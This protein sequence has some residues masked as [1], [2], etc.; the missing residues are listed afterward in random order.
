LLVRRINQSPK[1]LKRTTARV[2][3]LAV[4]FS[5]ALASCGGQAP[6]GGSLR[7]VEASFP[8]YLDPQLSYSLDGWLA[9]WNTY[10]PLLTYRHAPGQ[11]GTEVIPGLAQD[12]P[13]ISRGGK[14][15]TLQLRQGL[16]YSN[17]QPVKASD[18]ERAIERDF[19]LDSGAAP[20]YSDIVG[21]SDYQEG[22]SNQIRGI[23][24]DNQSGTIVINLNQPRGTFPNEL[25]LMFAAPVPPGTPGKDQTTSPIPGTGPYML[26]S[27]D[28]GHGFTL[29]RNPQWA[30]TNA[31]LL[32]DLPGGH[33]DKITET[34][35]KNLSSQ[36]TE[37]EHNQADFMVDPPPPDLLSE[38]QRD[39]GARFRTE[40]TVSVYYFWMNTQAPPFDDLRVRRA[41]NYALDPAALERL[42]GGLLAPSQ[43]I[44]PP[45]MPGYQKFE[46]YPHSQA[47]AKRLI[48]RAQ[49]SDTEITA[50]T[51]DVQ[52]DLQVGQ[53]YQDV[54][55]KLGFNVHLK[56][57]S[58]SIYFDTIGNVHTP[59]LDTGFSNWF[60]DYPHPNDFFSN[61]LYGDN[62]SPTHNNN[63]A[64]FNDARVNREISA[65]SPRL[66][67][68]DDV[69]GGYADLDRE[70]MEQAPLA[71]Y[72]NRELATFT[73]ERVDFAKVYLHP[74]FGQDYT[75]F[76]LDSR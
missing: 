49:P 30:K 13:E 64:L 22:S 12:L 50:W 38:V 59:D 25:A 35:K 19:D 4:A 56:V 68:E 71:P 48:E 16:R 40:P 55:K 18:F 36:V 45:S 66:L 57:I 74:V 33:V 24:T 2:L 60:Q 29:E 5:I 73:S 47:K 1:P 44:L 17:G 27:V 67:S 11:A 7:F 43:Q 42:Y 6:Q 9:M 20:F 39:Y 46:L 72:G 58:P 63:N 28:P 10:I 26:S 76:Q 3:G 65:L 69:V 53:Y 34:V 32:P 31:A 15:Y 8:D 51:D 75:S 70:I 61:L 52:P 14:T 54:L 37:V 21:A 23:Q 41:V 62:I